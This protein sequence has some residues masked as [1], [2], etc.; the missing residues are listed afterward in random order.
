MCA[1]AVTR[2]AVKGITRD[3]DLPVITGITAG[4]GAILSDVPGTVSAIVRQE[5]TF[6]NR[7]CCC[8]WLLLRVR[9]VRTAAPQCTIRVSDRTLR[10]HRSPQQVFSPGDG[11]NGRWPALVC[12]ARTRVWPSGVV[13]R[14]VAACRGRL[15]AETVPLTLASE[16]LIAR[17]FLPRSRPINRETTRYQQTG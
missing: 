8:C 1:D 14:D 15:V 2:A 12:I 4:G 9:T 13:H 17:H 16:A 10:V 11:N 6:R 5:I 3:H 7:C